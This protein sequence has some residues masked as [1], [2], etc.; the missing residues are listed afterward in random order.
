MVLSKNQFIRL[1]LKIQ[2][3]CYGEC[4][5]ASKRDVFYMD[6][7]RKDCEFYPLSPWAGEPKPPHPDQIPLPDEIIKVVRQ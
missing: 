2:I 1:K 3:Y 4:P 7:E 6:C 5:I